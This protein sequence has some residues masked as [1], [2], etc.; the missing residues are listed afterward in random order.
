MHA[1]SLGHLDFDSSVARVRAEAEVITFPSARIYGK[2]KNMKKSIKVEPKRRGR[3]ATG[4]DPV[5]GL[6][7]SPNLKGAVVKWAE[8][9]P[10]KPTLSEAT[11]RLVEIGLTVKAK[12]KQAPVDRAS[13]ARELAAKAIEKMGDPLATQEERVQRRRR[14]TRG[15]QEFRE[16]RVD[17]PETK[18]GK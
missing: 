18:R 12:S 14:L 4:R 9:Q 8:N 5:M 11:R 15:P 10:D 1:I 16:D 3:P 7:M 6:R 17:L 2:T 13:R